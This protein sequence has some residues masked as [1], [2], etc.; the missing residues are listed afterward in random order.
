VHLPKKG[1]YCSAI[2]TQTVGKRQTKRESE[3]GAV[4]GPISLWH[5]CIDLRGKRDT[6]TRAPGR[7]HLTARY[8]KLLRDDIENSYGTCR[9]QEADHTRTSYMTMRLSRP[10]NTQN[11]YRGKVEKD[12]RCW[13]QRVPKLSI[14]KFSSNP[15]LPPAASPA[16]G[17]ITYSTEALNRLRIHFAL[18]QDTHNQH[19]IVGATSHMFNGRQTCRQPFLLSHFKLWDT[20]MN[21]RYKTVE[22]M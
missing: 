11:S 2:R 14:P 21:I 22:K 17:T 16:C 10:H 20:L 18:A 7:L 8:V 4:G 12:G 19:A 5:V 1:A 3:W 9:T 15:I 6:T 13:N